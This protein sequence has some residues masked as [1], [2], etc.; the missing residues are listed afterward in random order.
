MR[1]ITSRI[2]KPS[3]KLPKESTVMDQHVVLIKFRHTPRKFFPNDPWTWSRGILL[4]VFS[5][6]E[7]RVAETNGEVE[8]AQW[9]ELPNL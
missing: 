2:Y 3:E 1:R 7:W 4:N 9:M 8:V 6:R 5:K